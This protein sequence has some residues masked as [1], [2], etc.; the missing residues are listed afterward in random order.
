MQNLTVNLDERY[1]NEA[2]KLGIIKDVSDFFN[3]ALIAY[4]ESKK[5]EMEKQQVLDGLKE[6]VDDVKND[7]VSDIGTLWN[8]IE[9]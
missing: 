9:D 2:I 6:A 1:L 7:R 8:S 5:A 3:R 4:V